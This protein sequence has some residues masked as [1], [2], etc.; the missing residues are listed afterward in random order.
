MGNS[1][2]EFDWVPNRITERCIDGVL[3]TPME[4]GK[5]QRRE[6][7][8]PRMAFLL[9]FNRDTNVAKDIYDFY[10]ARGGRLETFLF[11][12]PGYEEDFEVRFNTEFT[13][14]NAGGLVYEVGFEIIEVL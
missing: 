7:Y 5:E 12:P 11:S 9:R 2:P 10:E 3:I 1:L 14:S 4:G 13:R 8:P 6:K